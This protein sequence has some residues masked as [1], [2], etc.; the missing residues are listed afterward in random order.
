MRW[1]SKFSFLA[2]NPPYGAELFLVFSKY[3]NPQSRIFRLRLSTPG[4][5]VQN[6]YIYFICLK[7]FIIGCQF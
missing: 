5:K 3:S 6:L 4:E 7:C 1:T 2:K